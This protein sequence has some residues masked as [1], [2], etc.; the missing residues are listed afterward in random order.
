MSPAPPVPLEQVAQ[1][2]GVLVKLSYLSLGPEADPEGVQEFM[3]E[4]PDPGA[5]G[6]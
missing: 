6:L 2:Q 4:A 1:A 3:R 5:N